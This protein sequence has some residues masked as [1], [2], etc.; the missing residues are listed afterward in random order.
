VT[1]RIGTVLTA[2]GGVVGAAGVI[3]LATG[4]QITIPPDI[5]TLI[6]YKLLFGAAAGLMVAGAVI[7]RT[8]LIRKHREAAVETS[9][10]E[11]LPPPSEFSPP[12]HMDEKIGADREAP[13]QQ[14]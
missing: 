13:R 12:P 2:V 14:S 7:G 3:G 1:R 4:V 10:P 9:T 8:A 11:Q 6:F 5:V